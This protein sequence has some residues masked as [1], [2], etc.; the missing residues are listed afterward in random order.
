MNDFY[1]GYL[2][3]A[4]SDLAHFVRRV[5]IALMLLVLAAALSLV[6]GQTPFANSTFE[7]GKTQTFEGI[8]ETATYPV[9]LVAPPGE[10]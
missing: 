10:T 9:L 4:P 3:N 2:S 6:V 7:F 8:I 5:V 1:V